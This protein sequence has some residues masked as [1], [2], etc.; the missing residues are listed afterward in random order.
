LY[1]FIPNKGFVSFIEISIRR[2]RRRRRRRRLVRVERK[3]GRMK[4]ES[5]GG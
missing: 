4:R 1:T 2:R 5:R 3:R